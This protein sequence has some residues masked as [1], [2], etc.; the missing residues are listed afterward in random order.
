MTDFVDSSRE[1]L[2]GVVNT[3][4]GL[5]EAR[6]SLAAGVGPVAF[7]AE[8][9]HGHRYWPKAYLF[10]IRR[11]G[12]GTWLVDPTAFERDGNVDLSDAVAPL[13]DEVWLIHAASQDLA[14][15]REASIYPRRLFD[16]ELAGRLL[17]EPSVSLANLLERHLGIK[18]RKAHSAAD[19]STRP[20]P[21]AW[22]TYA[23][24]DVDYLVELHDALAVILDQRGRREWAEQEFTATVEQY[25]TDPPPRP[26]PWRRLSGITSLRQPRQLAVARSM[27]IE[28]D[29][30]A[31]AAD[32]PPGRVLSDGAIIAAATLARSGAPL[33]T[34]DSLAE[35]AEFRSRG[36][37][38]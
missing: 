18:L 35:L 36:A 24:L 10:Q 19:W 26:D 6:T 12:A 13:M 30:M 28:R 9:A 11:A 32:R 17:G 5:A 20:L 4:E 14:C 31:R 23:A 34:Q 1:P 25:R 2:R 8:R 33:P 15:M 21:E 16:T 29:L 22:L 27:W 38:R 7:D 3:D 37:R